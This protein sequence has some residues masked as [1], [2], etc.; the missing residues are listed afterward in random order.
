MKEPSR[1]HGSDAGPLCGPQA[2]CLRLVF[3]SVPATLLPMRL[4]PLGFLLLAA[5]D[6][7]VFLRGAKHLYCFGEK[8]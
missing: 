4:P 1:N 7:H 6:G 3:L 8:H 5:A 2:H